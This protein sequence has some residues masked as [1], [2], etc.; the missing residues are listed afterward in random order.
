MAK[1]I[2]TTKI[3]PSD[4]DLPELRYHFPRIYVNQV[5]QAVGDEVIF[6]EPRRPDDAASGQ[7]GRQAYFALGRVAAVTEDTRRPDHYCALIDDYLDFERPVEFREDGVF[8]ESALRREDG[9][10]NHGAFGHAVRIVPEGEF[11]MI[12][13]AGFLPG[14]RS[15][16]PLPI[17]G[18]ADE[19]AVFDRPIGQALARRPFRDAA[20]T[21][22]VRHAYDFTCAFS[23][24]RLIDSDGRAEVEAAHIRPVGDPHRGPDSIRNGIALGRTARWLFEHGLVALADD[25][26]ILI[27]RASL[28]E[29]LRRLFVA[30]GRARLPAGA[31]H[32]PHPQFLDYHRRHI[33]KGLSKG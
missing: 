24:L 26:E 9:S 5:R 3:R 6:Y 30:D 21:R 8:Y 15:G 25:G 14:V 29:G 23:G 19:P 10:V 18:L 12:R 16:K 33:F 11:E 20:F 4:D 28:P 32:R 2:L 7:D 13:N 1:A 31:F 27:A 22:N 17:P